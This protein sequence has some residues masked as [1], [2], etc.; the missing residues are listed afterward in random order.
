MGVYDNL[1]KYVRSWFWNNGLSKY[2]VL[3]IWS[4]EYFGVLVVGGYCVW[5][6]VVGYKNVV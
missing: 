6:Y 1:W 3:I 5:F 4:C 2:K